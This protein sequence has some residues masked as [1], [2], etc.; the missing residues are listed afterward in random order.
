[1]KDLKSLS[2]G[3][4]LREFSRSGDED[5]FAE[6][7]HRH[8]RTA[9]SAAF[10]VVGDAGM[11]EDIVQA[12]FL[13]LARKAGSLDEERALAGWI[14]R[15]AIRLGLHE[16]RGS[17]RRAAREQEAVKTY[18]GDGAT[19]T[20]CAPNITALHEELGGLSETYRVPVILHYLEGLSYEDTAAA[21][22][23]TPG[24]LSVRL[25]RAREKLN[26]SSSVLTVQTSIS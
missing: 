14:Y 8:G 1:M 5:A 22:G 21:V 13:T 18:Y 7:T 24:T 6:L 23:C 12:T 26:P 19:V 10:S 20:A 9:F 17:R 15:V 2:D 16:R 4:L 25:T 11:A 3:R